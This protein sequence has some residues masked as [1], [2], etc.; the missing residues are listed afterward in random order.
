[1]RSTCDCG[2]VSMLAD[3][4]RYALVMAVTSITVGLAAWRAR[5]ARRTGT[6]H[7]TPHDDPIS[8]GASTATTRPTVDAQVDGVRPSSHTE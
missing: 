4:W 3:V 8:P 5:R 6:E 2:G 7:P 1:M